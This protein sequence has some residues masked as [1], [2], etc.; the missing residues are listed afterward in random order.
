[1]SLDVFI[2][3]KYIVCGEAMLHAEVNLHFKG[4]IIIYNFKPIVEQNLEIVQN[5]CPWKW[6][7]FDM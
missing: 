1:M 3:G 5:G 7:P 2:L 6:I 4:I